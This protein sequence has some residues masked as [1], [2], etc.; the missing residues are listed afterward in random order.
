[1]PPEGAEVRKVTISNRI[2]QDGVEELHILAPKRQVA[3]DDPLF[4]AID[5]SGF[6]DGWVRYVL[7]DDTT[8]GITA[9][10][11]TS[12]ITIYDVGFRHSTTVT[13]SAKPSDFLAGGTQL[14]ILRCDSD[15]NSLFYVITGARNQGPNVVLDSVFRGD[16]RIQPH[17][18]WSTG[19]L[20]DS[21]QVPDGGID[22]MNRGELG[23][24]HGW[25]MGWG[26]VWNSTA[27]FLGDP[28]PSGI[29]QLVDRQ[30]RF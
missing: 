2:E 3:F 7:V 9:S 25:T 23:T 4:R 16:G 11:D 8:E 21:T 20:V 30:L 6:R 17:Q 28:E 19:F 5:L 22:L 10:S 29:C 12:R 1:M 26:V 24:G 18:R 14:L 15:G 13:S 27:S